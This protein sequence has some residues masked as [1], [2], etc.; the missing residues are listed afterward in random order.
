[1][2]AVSGLGVE[3]EPQRAEVVVGVAA[4]DVAHQV[5]VHREDVMRVREYEPGRAPLPSLA[6]SG[7]SSAR[8]IRCSAR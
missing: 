6:N 2:A 3:P 4:A 8:S 1:M 5:V 7:L